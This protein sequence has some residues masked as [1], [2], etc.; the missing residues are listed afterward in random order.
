MSAAPTIGKMVVPSEL[1][2]CAKVSRLCVVLGGPSRLISGFA[3]TWTITT[4]L[5]RTNSAN[6]KIA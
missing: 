5:A 6:R 2:A 3:T 1:N 4:P